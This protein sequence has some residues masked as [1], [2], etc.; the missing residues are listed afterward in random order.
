MKTLDRTKENPLPLKT[1]PGTA[2][3]TMHTNTKDGRP[4]L[5][6]TVGKTVLLCDARCLAD[7]H[8]MLAAHGDWMD[9]GGADEQKP[10]AGTIRETGEAGRGASGPRRKRGWVNERATFRAPPI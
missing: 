5:V 3:Y 2:D 4:I 1:P 10:E 7:L 9:L 6:F 8:A